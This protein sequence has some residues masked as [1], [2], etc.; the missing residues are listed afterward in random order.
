MDTWQAI[1]TIRAVRTFRPE[2]LP[3][4]TVE[5]ILDAG[6]HAGSSRN[7]QQWTF[8]AVTQTETLRAL[9]RVGPYARHIEGAALAVA[10]V[11]P[12][13]R[14]ANASL[15]LTWDSGRAAQNMVLAAWELGVGSVPATVYEHDLAKSILGLP[16]DKG[17]AYILSFGFPA[18]PTELSRPPRAGGRR[19]LDEVVRRE[20]W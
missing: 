19:R 18:D 12:D 10:L 13:P 1:R 7:T 6:R 4:A 5:R 9:G 20:R 15:S 8:V 2:P 14:A 17:C 3:E 11:T 16:Q